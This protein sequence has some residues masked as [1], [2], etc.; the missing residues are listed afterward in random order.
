MFAPTVVIAIGFGVVI[1][2][3]VLMFDAVG[4]HNTV[5]VDSTTNRLRSVH[6]NV[7]I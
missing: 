3:V 4:I 2:G 7:L 1:D 6:V 5:V